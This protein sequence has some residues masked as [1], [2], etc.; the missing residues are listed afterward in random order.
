MVVEGDFIR[1]EAVQMIFREGIGADGNIEAIYVRRDDNASIAGVL[2]LAGGTGSV[3]VRHP[4]QFT[5][6]F[7]EYDY[8][9]RASPIPAEDG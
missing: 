1:L 8:E 9:W 5:E 2:G 4:K 6:S 3:H 7:C